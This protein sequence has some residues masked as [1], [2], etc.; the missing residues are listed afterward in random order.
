MLTDRKINLW[1]SLRG[2][3]TEILLGAIFDNL[4]VADISLSVFAAV[5]HVSLNWGLHV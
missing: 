5:I 3:V 2:T 4:L 1:A